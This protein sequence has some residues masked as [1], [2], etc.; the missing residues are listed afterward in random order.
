MMVVVEFDLLVASWTLGAESLE[1][2]ELSGTAL[3][4]VIRELNT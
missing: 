3:Y 4:S 2:K 1:R